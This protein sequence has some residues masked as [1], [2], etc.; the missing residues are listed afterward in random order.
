[1][2]SE[3]LVLSTKHM[4]KSV[5]YVFFRE[6][7]YDFGGHF[8]DKTGFLHNNIHCELMKHYINSQRMKI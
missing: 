4:H 1:M 2:F 3:H 5:S 6:N 7:V 8:A